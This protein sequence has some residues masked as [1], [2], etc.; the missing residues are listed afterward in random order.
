MK[1]AQVIAAVCAALDA[2]GVEAAAALVD[3]EYPFAPET[4]TKRRTRV[5]DYTRVFL[6]DG[7][8][9]RYS[10]E[11]LV[12]PPVLRLLSTFM[13][14]RFPYHPNWKTHV[15]HAAYWEIGATIDHLRPVTRGGV[16]E[17]SNWITTS[18]A[19]NSAK[20]HW[21]LEELGWV[22]RPPGNLRE[23]DGLIHWCMKYA[24]DHGHAVA[25]NGV[26]QWLRAGSIALTEL[27]QGRS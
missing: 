5:L 21:T 2:D 15:T 10:G 25:D 14:D 22:L 27:E 18:M 8:V 24:L 11:R 4:P 9:D 3:R 20:M 23:W 26:R 19:R 6:R 17:P 13:P 12:F 1:K 16:D 7:F